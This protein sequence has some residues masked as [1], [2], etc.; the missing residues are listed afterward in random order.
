MATGCTNSHEE[1]TCRLAKR[2]GGLPLAL[3]QVAGIMQRRQLTFEGFLGF[4][5]DPDFPAGVHRLDGR[6]LYGGYGHV[7]LNVWS[8][9]GLRPE[10][11]RLLEVCSLLN[12]D[13]ISEAIFYSGGTVTLDTFPCTPLLLDQARSELLKC[14]LLKRYPEEKGELILALATAGLYVC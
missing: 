1:S 3:T 2:L 4:Y 6:D 11:V 8:F 12:S 5:N 14:S 13:R 7:L 9:E 10:S